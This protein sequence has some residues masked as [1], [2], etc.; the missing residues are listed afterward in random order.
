[1]LTILRDRCTKGSIR[2]RVRCCTKTTGIV[3]AHTLLLDHGLTPPP[4][5]SAAFPDASS[6]S[7]TD[8]GFP[9]R[10]PAEPSA[11]SIHRPRRALSCGTSLSHPASDGDT[12]T[13]SST[14][15]DRSAGCGADSHPG[16]AEDRT[17]CHAAGS[18]HHASAGSPHAPHAAP[19]PR[20]PP[21]GRTSRPPPHLPPRCPPAPATRGPPPHRSP[22]ARSRLPPGSHASEDRW[23]DGAS[24]RSDAWSSRAD[25]PSTRLRRRPSARCCRGSGGAALWRAWAA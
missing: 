20:T 6:H 21:D 14:P 8:T 16:P 23:P 4:A 5:H 1:M 7:T 18:L 12:P 2:E 10:L 13:L 19:P 9:P 15:H 25:G 22:P 11:G 3:L 17:Y 24:A